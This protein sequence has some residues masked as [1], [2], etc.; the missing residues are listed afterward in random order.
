MSI[1]LITLSGNGID[2]LYY[3]EGRL[4][5]PVCSDERVVA[6]ETEPDL[7]GEGLSGL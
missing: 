2:H 3:D 6:S 7:G 4:K 1:V 5:A